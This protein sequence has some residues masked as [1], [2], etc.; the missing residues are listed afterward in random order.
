MRVIGGDLRGRRL[1][2]PRGRT[3]RPTA[4][5]VKESLF[6]VLATVVP[7]AAVLDLF[8]GSGA[9]GIE[10]LSRGAERAVFVESNRSACQVLRQNI[11]QLGLH[12][13]AEVKQMT[14][15]SALAQLTA[16]GQRFD[17]LFVDPPYGH[18]LTGPV[19][20]QLARSSLLGAGATVAV[21]HDRRQQL[22]TEVGAE[23]QSLR[24]VRS[25][26][27]GDTAIAIYRRPED[28]RPAEEVID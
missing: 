10:A 20:E 5:R 19:L 13:R 17:L 3:T 26:T 21:E 14:V 28:V 18:G 16:S 25:L 2:A 27:Y 12:D 15:Q 11:A 23:R 24:C 9:L 8:A 22:P 1:T 4:D 7:G 6:N